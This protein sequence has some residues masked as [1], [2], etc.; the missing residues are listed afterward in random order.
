M[1]SNF[2]L[3]QASHEAGGLQIDIG[4]LCLTRR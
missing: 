3:D 2:M 1:G 4:A